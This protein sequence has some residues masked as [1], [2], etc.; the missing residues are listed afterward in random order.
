MI[1]YKD[2][3]DVLQYLLKLMKCLIIGGGGFVGSWL[4][5]EMLSRGHRVI[6]IDPFTYHTNWSDKHIKTINIFKKDFLLKGAKIYRKKFEDGGDKILEEENPDIVIHLAGIPVE[7]IDD[8]DISLKQLTDDIGLTYRIVEAVRSSQ[9]K[10]FIFMSSISAYGDCD[11]VITEDYPLIPKTPYGIAKASGEFITRSRLDNWNVVRTTNIYGFGDMN[12]R[13]SNIIISK[14]LNGEK[15]WINKGIVMDFIYVK[16]L[17][18]GIADVSLKAPIQETFHISGNKA[19]GLI[20]FV[21]ILQEYF[22]LD[23]EIKEIHDRP[24]RGTMHNKKARKIIGWHPKMD[25]H[26]GIADYIKYVKKYKIP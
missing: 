2:L 20:K 6:I 7:K 5:R 11:K 10:K 19:V 18:A 8:F 23:Y 26:S 17:V 1:L 25:I 13:A 4:A 14:I 15:F 24:V 12:G 9:V 21:K 22:D 16:D 3:T